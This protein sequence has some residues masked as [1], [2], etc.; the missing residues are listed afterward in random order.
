MVKIRVGLINSTFRGVQYFIGKLSFKKIR[1][2]IIKTKQ[3]K[4]FLKRTLL[5][6]YSR[7]SPRKNGY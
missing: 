3:K 4:Y 6:G 2:K 1:K 5:L 7:C